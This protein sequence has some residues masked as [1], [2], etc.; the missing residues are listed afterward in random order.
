MR[1]MEQRFYLVWRQDHSSMSLEAF[2][3]KDRLLQK[4][5]LR[6]RPA[7]LADLLKKLLLVRR[8]VI[9]TSVGRFYVDPVSNLSAA[10]V[11]GGEYEPG[12]LQTLR[13]YLRPSATFVDI[14]ANEGYFTVHGANLVGPAGRVIA[15]EPQHRLSQVLAH[16]FALNDRKNIRILSCAVSDASGTANLYVS[17]D[18]N[19]GC[20]SLYLP[21]RYRLP[22][23]VVQTITLSELFS[24]CEIDRADLVKMD[25]E[26]AEYAAILG[27]PDLFRGHRIR[28]LALELHPTIIRKRNL[29][30]NAIT[31]FL[32]RSGYHL[33]SRL[34]NTVY[35][36]D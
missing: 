29:D 32:G 6:V 7:A 24:L 3:I 30:P 18:T 26:G 31:E 15:V 12:M 28:A 16:N 25:I 19:T 22:T 35:V 10:L 34:E 36:A 1:L 27:S 8:K 2:S 11:N 5:L 9:S 21:T 33:D 20:T 4:T 13:H 23:E 17:P 14:G